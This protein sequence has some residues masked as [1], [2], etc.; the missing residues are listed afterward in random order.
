[1]IMSWDVALALVV[2][3]VLALLLPRYCSLPFLKD[4]YA[5]GATVM[6]IVFSMFTAALAIIVSSPSDKFIVFLEEDGLF[7]D[8]LFGFRLTLGA[9]FMALVTSFI[10][11]AWSS[12]QLAASVL[13]Q[14]EFGAIL[15]GFVFT[16]ALGATASTTYASIQYAQRRAEFLRLTAGRSNP[17]EG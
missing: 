9:L 4:V 17:E 3:L 7:S 6:S 12:A 1:M 2:A 11:F 14:H 15:F 5:L 10:L 13:T 16:Y 8:M